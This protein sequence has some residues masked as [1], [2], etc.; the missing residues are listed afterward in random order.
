MPVSL[1]A[2]LSPAV[3]AFLERPKNLLIGGEW[4]PAASGATFPTYDPATGQ[5][6][7][8]VAK[9][10]SE[11]VDR[12][13]SAARKAFEGAAWRNMK[14]HVRQQLLWKVGDLITERA[15]TFGQLESLDTGKPS[16]IAKLVDADWSGDQFRYAAGWATRIT[17]QTIQPAMPLAPDSKFLAYTLREPYGVCAGITPWNYPLI[18]ATMKIAPALAAGN[19]IVLKPAEETPLTTLLLGELFEEAGF[20][21]GVV[22][23]VTGFGEAGARLAEHPDVDKIGFTGSTEVGRKVLSAAGGNLKKVSLE[24][25]GKSPNIVF[26]DADFEAAVAGAVSAITFNQGESCVAGTR[27]FVQEPLFDEFTRAVAKAASQLKVGPGI[28][29][30]TQIGPMIS[31]EHLDRVAGYVAQGQ[32]DGARALG[33][34]SSLPDSGYYIEPTVLVDVTPQMSVYREEIFGPVVVA[35]PFGTAEEAI[36]LANDTS[37]GLAAGVWTKDLSTAHLVAAGVKAGSVWVNQYNAFDTA[38]PF[39]GYKASGW[40]RELG[41]AVDLYLQTKAVNIQLA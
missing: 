32:A 27:L 34:G 3:R 25:G 22:N 19:T 26:A 40:G 33:G 16:V 39:G 36:A 14:P 41:D 38:L 13:V 23:V 7:A 6:L 9:G 2:T 35:L 37:F 18:M 17:G 12:A 1:T 11:D 29:P 20:P 8:E 28:D 5:V 4:T 24:L 30:T 21:P 10:S 15:E 31:Q